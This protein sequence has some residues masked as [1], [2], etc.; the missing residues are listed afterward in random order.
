MVAASLTK[1]GISAAPMV[2]AQSSTRAPRFVAFTRANPSKGALFA[3]PE[4]SLA[5]AVAGRVSIAQVSKCT[6]S[7][8][9]SRCFRP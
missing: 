8:L 1:A 9:I 5:Q 7:R 6:H 3:K 2:A 4:R